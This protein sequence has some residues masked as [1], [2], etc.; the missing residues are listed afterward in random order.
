M[1]TKKLVIGAFVLSTLLTGCG[2]KDKQAASPTDAEST[3]C[4]VTFSVDSGI[5]EDEF[6]LSLESE[7]GYT[8][9]YTTDGSNPRTSSTAK[10]YKEPIRITDRSGDDNVVSAVEPTLF[11]SNFSYYNRTEGVVCNIEAPAKEA[12]DKCTTVRAVSKKDDEYTDAVGE[13][14]FIGTME[15]HIEGIAE[16]CEAAG[17]KLAVI[18]ISMDYD[19]LFDSEKGIYVKGNIFDEALAAAEKEHGFDAEASR[20]IP[21]NYNQR[22]K[23]WERQAHMQ[24][25]EAD[26]SG[27]T[28]V[29]NQECGIRIQGNYSRS[30]L[31]KSFR[32]YAKKSYG[33]KNF[34]YAVWGEDATNKDGEVLDKFKTLVL[35]AGGNCAFT[36]KYNDTYWQTLA[37]GVDCDTKASR[38]CVVYLNGEYWGLYV[39]EEDYTEEYFERHYGVDKNTVIAYKGDAETYSTG[40]KLDLGELPAKETTSFYYKELKD[41]FIKHK[42]LSAKEDYDEFAKLVDVSSVMDYFAVEVFINNKWDWPGK[43]W[44]MWKTSTVDENNEYADGRWRFS[45]YDIEFG[46]VSGSMDAY[47]NT[48]KEDNYKPKGLL[49]FDTS[50]PAVLCFA[51]LMT[52]SEFNEAYRAR[53]VELSNTCFE[54]EK[55]LKALDNFEAVYGPLFD[56]F[57]ERYPEAGSKEEALYGGY[58]SSKCI[59]DFISI[60]AEHLEDILEYCKTAVK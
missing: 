38:P 26:A 48:V 18:S 27:M 1:R 35:R 32:L 43:N 58:A 54:K 20:K 41:F 47:T 56:Q 3:A 12:V 2:S 17:R 10:E 15:E 33:K 21:A 16:S 34:K 59:R 6:E 14:Y 53:L 46:G 22:G 13:T 11:C 44:T 42:D 7:G 9:Y 52:N 60:R 37:K 8:I 23:D 5:Y 30:D 49:D 50:N 57:Y 51:Y 31:Q 25:Y 29:L 45:L 28:E 55:A 4:D 36:A 40:Y 39:L 24:M 19:D